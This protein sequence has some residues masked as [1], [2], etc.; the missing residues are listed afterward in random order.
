VN[1]TARELADIALLTAKAVKR[2]KITPRIAMLSYGNFGSAKGQ[3]ATKMAEAVRIL[4]DEAPDLVVD[5]EMQANFAL[6]QQ[7]RKEIF[8]F[9]ELQRRNTNVLIFPNLSA[10]NIAYKLMQELGEL[11]ST[12]PVLIGMRKS[13]HVLQMGSSVREILNMVRIAVVD[14]QTK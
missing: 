9:S 6:N 3:D 14:A 10:G 1:P 5:G 13:F 4:H 2:M 12:G 7:L 8:P 11:E